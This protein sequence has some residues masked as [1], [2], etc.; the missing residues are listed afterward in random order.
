MEETN[1]KYKAM[2]TDKLIIKNPSTIIRYGTSDGKVFD[3]KHEAE[4]HD[5]VISR[6]RYYEYLLKERN[7]FMRLFNIKPSMSFYDEI[8]LKAKLNRRC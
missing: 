1:Y 3:N 5:E 6:Q 2:L 8:A 7:W 4:M